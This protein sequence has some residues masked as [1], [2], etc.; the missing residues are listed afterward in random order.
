MADP[1]STCARC[2]AWHY[3]H[4]NSIEGKHCNAFV[5]KPESKPL[6]D[7]EEVRGLVVYVVTAL[8]ESRVK[9][10]LVFASLVEA[11]AA[12]HRLRDMY[13]GSLVAVTCRKVQ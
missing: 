6:N 3:T 11:D 7:V 9:E 4:Q 10:Q 5:P 1:Y 13:R 12:F 2:G 8:E